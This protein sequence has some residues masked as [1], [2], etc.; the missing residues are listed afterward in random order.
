MMKYFLLWHSL[1]A[2]ALISII[3]L[4]TIHANEALSYSSLATYFKGNQAFIS[5][6]PSTG[7]VEHYLLEITET[8]FLSRGNKSNALTTVQQVRTT[9]PFYHL[10]CK[11]NHSYQVSVKAISSAGSSSA[12]SEPSELFICDQKSPELTLTSLPSSHTLRSPRLTISGFFREPHLASLTVNGSAASINLAKSTFSARVSLTRGE[13]RVQVSARDLAGNS[14][15]KTLEIT[16]EP[17]SYTSFSMKGKLYPFLSDYN[18]DEKKD[19]LVGTEQGMIALFTNRG[20]ADQP[21]WEDYQLL[22][23]ET[24]SVLDVGTHAVPRLVDFN[25]DGAPDLLVGSGE[26]YLYY[27]ANQGSPAE[28]VFSAPRVLEDTSGR[29]LAVEGHCKPFVVDWDY[30]TT[31]D[32]L[33]GSGSGRVVLYRNEVT[34][35]NGLFS[36][37]LTIEVAGA[38]LEVA[39]K[40]VPYVLDWDGDGGKDLV[41]ED[42]TGYFHLYLNSVVAGEPDL[43]QGGMLHSDDYKLKFEQFPLPFSFVGNLEGL[44]DIL[45][46]SDDNHIYLLSH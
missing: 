7:P 4:V 33:L 41:V 20:T 19:L 44:Q 46:V 35:G 5:W 37:P 31:Q 30:D 26:G 2:I 32:I 24:G 39:G 22:I 43:Y 16:Y 6:A 45:A 40:A 42:E 12:H 8:Q 36:P 17:L 34:D 25:N 27:C 11:H 29:T 21:V 18:L 14:T 13:N 38:A 1:L 9:S 3:Y 10:T 28:P 15:S 23:S